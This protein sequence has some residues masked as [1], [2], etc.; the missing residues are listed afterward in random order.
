NEE[1][2]N[3]AELENSIEEELELV[4]AS[5]K[6]GEF[7][8]AEMEQGNDGFDVALSGEPDKEKEEEN[9]FDDVWQDIN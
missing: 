9:L 4:E 7:D 5:E 8:L 6:D 2:L 1:D 3:L